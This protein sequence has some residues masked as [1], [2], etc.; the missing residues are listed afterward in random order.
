MTRP[1]LGLEGLPLSAEETLSCITR[2]VQDSEPFNYRNFKA[3]A[4]HLVTYS[5]LILRKIVIGWD[6]NLDVP[7]FGILLKG[8]DLTMSYL[9]D[10]N[11]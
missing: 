7:L 1:T 6:V 3:V 2:S 5:N 9:N 10:M 11:R 4:A 8:I